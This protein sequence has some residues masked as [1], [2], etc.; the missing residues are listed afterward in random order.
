MRCTCWKKNPDKIDWYWLSTNTNAVHLLE[1]NLDKINWGFLLQNPCI[2]TY[3]YQ[4]MR[5]A[6]TDLKEEL[7]RAAW[8][9][10]RVSAWLESG[11]D[12]EDL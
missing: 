12:L 10:S 3:D 11:M 2:F 9:P 1:R 8:H 7:I 5:G 4:A 6:H